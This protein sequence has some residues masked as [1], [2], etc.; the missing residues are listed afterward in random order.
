MSKPGQKTKVLGIHQ[1]KK[2]SIIKT[3][4]LLMPETRKQFWLDFPC[5]M[6]A[7]DLYGDNKN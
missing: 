3:L 2:E 5:A 7:L 1:S 4:V 6:E